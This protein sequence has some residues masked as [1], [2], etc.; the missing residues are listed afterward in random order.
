MEQGHECVRSVSH[1]VTRACEKKIKG[2]SSTHNPE[3]WI[4]NI[5]W[6]SQ[7]GGEL[8][9]E[10]TKIIIVLRLVFKDFWSGIV[11]SH[12]MSKTGFTAFLLLIYEIFL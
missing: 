9:R 8:Q 6:R 3:A 1:Q 10:N 4:N 7:G 12:L 5:F 2:V 11:C